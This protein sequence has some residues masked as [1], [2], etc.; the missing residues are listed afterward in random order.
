[1]R[2]ADKKVAVIGFGLSGRAAA[3][4]LLKKKAK[5]SVFDEKSGG[6]FDNLESLEKKGVRFNLGPFDFAKIAE[7]ELIVMSPG[8][9]SFKFPEFRKLEQLGKEVISEIELAWRFLKGKLVCITGTNGKSTTTSLVHH[10]FK[11]A[12]RKSYLLGNIGTP[13]I[14]QVE[15]IGPQEYAVVEVSCFQLEFVQTF[16]PDYTILTNISADHLDRYPSMKSYIETRKNIF[17]N[18]TPEDRIIL[19]FDDPLTRKHFSALPRKGPEVL[20]GRPKDRVYPVRKRH[21]NPILSNGVYWFSCKSEVPRGAFLRR[22]NFIFRDKKKISFFDSSDFPLLGVHN[23]EN[24]LAAS[25][26]PIL[27]GV[28]TGLIQ[29]GLKNFKGLKHRMEF[30]TRFG[31]VDF[32]NDSK[33]TNVDAVLKAIASFNSE[34]NRAV[35]IIG[36][37]YKGGDFSLLKTFLTNETKLVLMGEAA[38]K[39]CVQLNGAVWI[40]KA[41]NMEEA[42][43]FSFE[44]AKPQGVVLLSPGCASFDMFNNFEHRGEVFKEEVMRLKERYLPR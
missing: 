44:E 34:R 27:E 11:T 17:K 4:F 3:D 19:N 2:L 29:K 43:R 5:I 31:G 38:S 40:K 12:G 26:P 36:G 8:V 32:I 30:V 18:I 23:I 22:D 28:E 20:R 10:L 7:A 15:N 42:V 24:A 16:K 35:V 9:S 13:F 14:S 1:L 6:E 39:I 41:R 21:Q 37:K 25:L 33:A